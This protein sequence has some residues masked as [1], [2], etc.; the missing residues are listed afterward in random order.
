MIFTINLFIPY[1]CTKK[2]VM[3]HHISNIISVCPILILQG[4]LNELE[5]PMGYWVEGLKINKN[6][7]LISAMKEIL[8]SSQCLFL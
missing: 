8:I 3:S 1:T 7:T 2:I 4:V 5:E 6:A